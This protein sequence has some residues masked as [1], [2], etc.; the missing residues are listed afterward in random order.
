[1][2]HCSWPVHDVIN[3]LSMLGVIQSVED[4]LYKLDVPFWLSCW[5]MVTS[6]NSTWPPAPQPKVELPVEQFTPSMIPSAG[7]IVSITEKWEKVYWLKTI[8]LQYTDNNYSE[9]FNAEQRTPQTLAA[10]STTAF[11][12]LSHSHVHII[13]GRVS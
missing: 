13:H 6:V 7:E 5:L 11:F 10:I 2:W 4:P 12:I 8:T 9:Q 3:G 1:M